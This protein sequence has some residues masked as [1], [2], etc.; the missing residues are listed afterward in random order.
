MQSQMAEEEMLQLVRKLRDKYVDKFGY[1]KKIVINDCLDQFLKAHSAAPSALDLKELDIVMKKRILGKE[2]AYQKL[3]DQ[4]KGKGSFR[5]EDVQSSEGNRFRKAGS[6]A[7]NSA[8]VARKVPNQPG[9][10]VEK[11]QVAKVTEKITSMPAPKLKKKVEKA[12]PFAPNANQAPAVDQK[13]IN[14]I[15][16]IPEPNPQGS[17]KAVSK[18]GIID[19]YETRKLQQEVVDM[20]QRK[21]DSAEEYKKVLDGQVSCHNQVKKLREIEATASELKLKGHQNPKRPIDEKQLL[22]EYASI[23]KEVEKQNLV[24]PRGSDSLTKNS[25]SSGSRTSFPRRWCS[26][27]SLRRPRARSRTRSR[28][29]ETC[30][31]GRST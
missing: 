13:T 12:E 16:S 1:A 4:P 18:W 5:R 27:G 14:E 22:S 6:E 11:E 21:K 7:L 3:P 26:W 19:I 10:A 28:N 23:Q 25:R 20:R 15:L 29:T 30:W 17:K 24:P 8:K 9:K 2:A 31:T